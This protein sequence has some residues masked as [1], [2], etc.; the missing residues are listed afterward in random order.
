MKSRSSAPACTPGA[1]GAT[2]S[3]STAWPPPARHWPTPVSAG[4]TFALSPA[5]PPCA[6]A[7]RV[8]SPAPPLPRRWAGR[9]PRSTLP[10]PPAP[11]APR[12][13]QRR[14]TRSSPVNAR[15]PWWWVPTPRPRVSLHRPAATVR[16]IRTGCVFTWVSPTPPTSP[17][18]HGGVWTCTATPS[19]TSRR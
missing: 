13:W 2:I 16:R 4:V 8:T 19:K 10:T 1:S 6:A 7:T 5:A 15:S 14:A 3:S 17:C 11:P 9:E 12:P 18:T